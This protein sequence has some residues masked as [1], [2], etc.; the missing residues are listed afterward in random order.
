MGSDEAVGSGVRSPFILGVFIRQAADCG[1]WKRRTRWK[2]RKRLNMHFGWTIQT[3]NAAETLP[4]LLNPFFVM[5]RMG[6]LNVRAR[7]LAGH[8]NLPLLFH[9][10]LVLV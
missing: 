2:P 7:D 1:S 5:P 9:T 8:W 10:P 3:C 6:I 4:N